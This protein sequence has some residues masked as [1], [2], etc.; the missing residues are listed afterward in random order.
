MP[1]GAGRRPTTNGEETTPRTPMLPLFDA[2][3]DQAE[4]D[5]PRMTDGTVS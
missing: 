5:L 3:E 2:G 1:R 4:A